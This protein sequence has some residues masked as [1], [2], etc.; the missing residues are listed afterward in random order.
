M[1]V[2]NN[3]FLEGLSGSLGNI[4]IYE[5]NGKTIVRSKPGYFRDKKSPRHL[6]QRQKMKLVNDFLRP[7]IHIYPRTF[8]LENT[9]KSPFYFA[10]SYNMKFG[11]KGAY[12]NLEIDYTKALFSK[13]SVPLPK[14]ASATIQGKDL[15]VEWGTSDI[16]FNNNRDMDTLIL[17]M[18]HKAE[19]LSRYTF[20]GVRRSKGNF[21][22]EGVCNRNINEMHLWIIFRNAA[23]SNISDSMFVEIKYN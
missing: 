9:E 14:E 4:V 11:V 18:R 13:G 1:A 5:L 10:K 2:L 8:G 3:K 19:N 20:S 23:E 16:E 12:P 15:L 21:L 6:A 7:F 22:W 17:L